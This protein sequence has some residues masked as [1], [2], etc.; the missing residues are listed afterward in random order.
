MQDY[1]GGT[2]TREIME[3]GLWWLDTIRN[4]ELK[5]MCVRNPHELARGLECD[6]R[7]TAG[8]II[9]HNSLARESS[10]GALSFQRLDFPEMVPPEQDCFVAVHQQDGQVCSE[11]LPL[12]FWLQGDNAPTY[13]ENYLRRREEE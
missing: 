2:K 10:S 3:T 13:R 12:D 4:T 9:L 8:E 6:V 1:A 11:K 5:Q 7:L